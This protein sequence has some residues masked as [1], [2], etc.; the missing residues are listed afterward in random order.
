MKTSVT[1][2][3]KKAFDFGV[4]ASLPLFTACEKNND[5]PSQPQQQKH[6]V[7]LVYGHDFNT[8]WQ[9][10]SMDTLYKYHSDQTVDSIF[11]VLNDSHQFNT[12]STNNLKKLR[13]MLSERHNINTNKIFGK[14]EM[15]LKNSSIANNPEIVRFFADTLKYTVTYRD[16]KSR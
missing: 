6:N 7:E 4:I 1:N 2:K 15:Q 5:N 8:Q 10:I 14:G 16:A 13:N 9:N 12:L 3:M 11:M